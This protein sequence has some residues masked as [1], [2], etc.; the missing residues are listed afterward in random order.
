M[1]ELVAP[2]STG[3]GATE[4]IV[5]STG[6]PEAI[7]RTR[8]HAQAYCRCYWLD[9]RFGA[10]FAFVS[11]PS[12][13]GQNPAAA[14]GGNSPDGSHRRADER[15]QSGSCDDAAAAAVGHSQGRQYA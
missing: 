10:Q 12:T 14:E 1:L 6:M 4:V 9:S 13:I 2:A 8:G 5:Q 11:N 7:T 3:T 15:R